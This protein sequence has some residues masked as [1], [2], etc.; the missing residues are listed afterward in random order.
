MEALT[1]TEARPTHPG[2]E[3][4]IGRLA[5][6]IRAWA[7]EYA[8]LA[9]HAWYESGEYAWA[10]QPGDPL[11]TSDEDMPQEATKG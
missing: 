2:A 8:E 1:G 9:N 5:P 10:Q 6:S 3:D 4:V 11:W 7:A